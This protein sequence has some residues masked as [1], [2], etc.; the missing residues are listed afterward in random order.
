MDNGLLLLL[1]GA[2]EF[3]PASEAGRQG[4]AVGFGAS[5]L[6]PLATAVLEVLED[7]AVG[8]C[9]CRSL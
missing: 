4:P 2:G 6:F 5:V 8:G 3:R 9:V 1:L 7:I